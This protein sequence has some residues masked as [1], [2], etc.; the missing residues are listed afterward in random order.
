MI[1]LS[2]TWIAC[3]LLLMSP[4]I[5]P[6]GAVEVLDG[7]LSVAAP[8]I[9]LDP[10]AAVMVELEFTAADARLP[11]RTLAG[12]SVA[13]YLHPYRYSPFLAEPQAL[14]A[15]STGAG[16]WTVTLPASAPGWYY[17]AAAVSTIPGETP[18]IDD[19]DAPDAPAPLPQFD[20]DPRN[21]RAGSALVCIHASGGVPAFRVHAERGRCVFAQGE[22]LRLFA[23]VRGTAAVRAPIELLLAGV[24]V[25]RGDLAAPA[26]REATVAFDLPSTLTAAL[27]AGRTDLVLK[28][29]GTE[30]DRLAVQVVVS[31]PVSGR[32]RWWHGFPFGNASANTAAPINPRLLRSYRAWAD[33]TARDG[34]H[35]NLWINWFSDG[36]PVLPEPIILP[37]AD[38]PDAPP[39]AAEQRPAAV[40]AL[41]ELL[42]ADGIACGAMLG[43]AEGGAENYCPFPTTD[44]THIALVARKYQQAA[45]S[46]AAHPNFTAVYLDAYGRPDW[47]G[48]G[49]QDDLSEAEATT[50]RKTIWEAAWK[51]AGAQPPAGAEITLPTLPEGLAPPETRYRFLDFVMRGQERMYGATTRALEAVLPG[52][53]TIHNHNREN[54]RQPIVY[55]FQEWTRSPSIAPDFLQD[56]ATVVA[57][58]EWNLDAEPQAYLLSAELNR[59]LLDRGHPVWR[60]AA[61]HF[62]GSSGR[63][64]RDAVQLSGRGIT[65]FFEQPETAS[66]SQQGADQ[67][68]FAAK[69]R[70]AGVTAF[71]T[72]YEG[73]FAQLEPVR[74]VAFYLRPGW[75]DENSLSLTTGLPAAWM[76]GHQAHVLS[77]G[78]LLAGD[79]AKYRILFAPGLPAPFTYPAEAAAIHDW[80]AK[81]GKIIGAPAATGRYRTLVDLT[82]FGITVTTGEPETDGKGNPKLDAHGKPVV[83]ETYV[84][85]LPARAAA[86]AAAVWKDFPGTTVLPVDFTKQ[87]AYRDE[88]GQ[89]M[90]YSKRANWT[91]FQMWANA[92]IPALVNSVPLKAA[93]DALEQPLIVKDRPEVLI[94]ALRPKQAGASGLFLFAANFTV[95]KEASWIS[96]RVPYFFWP[97]YSAPTRCRIGVRDEGVGVVYDLLT[98]KTVPCERRDGRVWFDI[99]LTQVEGRVYACYPA[100]VTTAAMELP[101]SAAPGELLRG[102]WRV[103]G[104]AAPLTSV[105]VRLRARSGALLAEVCRAVGPDGQLPALKIPAADG[106]LLVEVLDTV[107]GFQATATVVL[108]GAAPTPA[109]PA[110]A[111]TVFRGDAINRLLAAAPGLRIAV[112]PGREAWA[113]D[114]QRRVV[115]PNPQLPRDQAAAERLRAALTAA[116]V[117][118]TVADPTTVVA[119]Q[120][121]AYPFAGP[122]RNHHTIPNRRID[123]PVIVIGSPSSN[124]W[125][126]DMEQAEVAPRSLGRD[127]LGP[128]RAVVAFAPLAFSPSADALLVVA[129]DDTG[130]AA[131]TATLV[132]LA[133]TAPGPDPFYRAREAVR[134]GYAPTDV[135]AYKAARGVVP[136]VSSLQ[137]AAGALISSAA[138]PSG[139]GGAQE[140]LGPPVFSLCA[141]PSGV[142]VSLASLAT[143]TVLVAA[144]GTVRLRAGGGGRQWARDVGISADGQTVLA[145]FALSAETVAIGADGKDR[146]HHVAG[147]VHK[148]DPLAWETWKDSERFLT[149]SPD[150]SVALVAAGPDGVVCHDL[151]TG[152]VRWTV[153][154]PTP[155]NRPRGMPC[156]QLAIS[157]DGSWGLVYQQRKTGEKP[158]LDKK[159]NPR[160]GPDGKP[161]VDEQYTKSALLVDMHTGKPRWSSPVGAT[162]DWDLNAAVGPQGAW[163]MVASRGNR[164]ALRDA[165]GAVLRVFPPEQLPSDL[166]GAPSAI[167]PLM[168]TGARSDRF[169]LTRAETTAVCVMDLTLGTPAQRAA[170]VAALG[171]LDALKSQLGDELRDERRQHA[172]TTASVDAFLTPLALPEPA[173]RLLGDKMKRFAPEAAA[174]RQRNFAWIDE[175]YKAALKMAFDVERPVI[176]SA[177]DLHVRRRITLPALLHHAI[178]TPD[179]STLY[180]GLWDGTVRAY[181]V[182]SGSQKWQADLQGGGCQL[183]LFGSVLYAGGSRGDLWRLDAVSGVLAWHRALGVSGQ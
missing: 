57:S 147:V 70:L 14:P 123:G 126:A 53:F 34:H 132:Q 119:D 95:P 28:A 161:Q 16:R 6:L 40:H 46:L 130:F 100:P 15:K 51:A 9:P 2:S 78:G 83:R 135:L 24:V 43:G 160:L 98:T 55:A 182:E 87:W 42:M 60:T 22:Q 102:T 167:P 118:V 176:E 38:A 85:P 154:S 121:S 48:R 58:S 84:D 111:V 158:V 164:L 127:N 32:A 44:P 104:P 169:L 151:A 108:T 174:G 41:Y 116:G 80:V 20:L 30:A 133:R 93:F 25:A 52:A 26:G 11:Q 27:P 101:A 141:G 73:L 105:R 106:P 162:G 125:L 159:G 117:R 92:A 1:R 69:D 109:T 183:D 33:V 178:V 39:V 144:D 143:P 74:E 134:A 63:F 64:M 140:L 86:T 99:D 7:R 153:P 139:W 10:G 62:N 149:V 71:L 181:D 49:G 165:D 23:S 17:L 96:P 77:Y 18:G 122:Y 75:G 12:R 177:C 31:E 50:A 66:W 35:A 21:P 172:W 145:G 170:S 124:S 150:R 107:N 156:E 115:E 142:A 137:A 54:H 91:S 97:T 157:P 13:F 155:L 173:K 29:A 163:T 89:P 94:H 81:G 88:Q 146:W 171:R 47:H 113:K 138:A 19:D 129:D 8:A 110:A 168:L 148:D 59:V 36:T 76:T 82:A 152:A 4:L 103:A 90:P 166:A 112:C 68:A 5:S 180:A 72:I 45:L 67:S 120:L 136:P 79:L 131:A 128:G 56:A 175:E 3:V 179:L 37:A 61:F 114:G 65:P